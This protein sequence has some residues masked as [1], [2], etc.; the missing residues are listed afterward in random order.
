MALERNRF[1]HRSSPHK[2]LEAVEKCLAW[3]RGC[4]GGRVSMQLG[5]SGQQL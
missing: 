4:P 5:G 1:R 2:L 3:S